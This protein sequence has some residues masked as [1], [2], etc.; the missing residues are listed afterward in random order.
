MGSCKTPS[1]N[2]TS[3]HKVKAFMVRA[4][5]VAASAAAAALLAEKLD[6][7]NLAGNGEPEKGESRGTA[8]ERLSNDM[9]ESLRLECRKYC[10]Y[11]LGSG[12]K[13]PWVAAHKGN[14]PFPQ[15]QAERLEELNRILYGPRAESLD[16]CGFDILGVNE[17]NFL[18]VVQFSGAR[19]DSYDGK[20]IQLRVAFEGSFSV[21]LGG[22]FPGAVTPAGRGPGAYPVW[23]T[24]DEFD[25][26]V[27]SRRRFRNI[28]YKL[29]KPSR[30]FL[31]GKRLRKRP[32]VPRMPP[33]KHINS[34]R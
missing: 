9:W 4:W 14:A 28:K 23:K 16:S 11:L 30:D 6:L 25:F 5:C 15:E 31:M 18:A 3:S 8:S 21:W 33:N 32:I 19:N 12:E 29:E 27:I 17:R 22:A 10:A 2:S 13:R 20:T 24:S 1:D 7:A 34:R 26:G